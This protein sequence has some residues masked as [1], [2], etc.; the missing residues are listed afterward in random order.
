MASKSLN[1]IVLFCSG[2]MAAGGEQR[3]L[4]EEEKFFRAKGIETTV[5]TFSLDRSALYDYKPEKLEVIEAGPSFVSRII[6]LR[7][8]L[9]QINPDIVIASSNGG[10]VYL[11]LATMFTSIPYMVHIHGTLFWFLEDVIKYAFIHKKVFSGIRESVI[12]HKEFIPEQPNCS[13]SRRIASEFFAILDYLAVRK[14]RKIIVLTDQLKWEVEELYGREAVVARGCLPL[15]ALS[16]QPKEDVRQKLGLQNKRIIFSVGRLDPR[17][18]ID[19]LI[20]SFARILPKY[21]NL[22]LLIGGTG[23][24]EERLK[25]LAKELDIT[26][27]VKFLGFIPDAELF[28]YYAACDVFAFPSWTTSGITPYEALAV[29]K[30]VVWTTEADEPILGDE[31]VFLADPVVEDF[32]I[33]LEEAINADVKGKADLSDYTWDKYFETVYR[34]VIEAINK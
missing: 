5:L 25:K 32:A 1:K 17:K 2:L 30:K 34:A 20:K 9:Q 11:Y 19:V 18:R 4:W 26:E 15:E 14:A 31:H 13:F 16:Y 23:E 8:K 3:L 29:G 6:A 28:D 10:A 22:Y 27:R 12:G 21:G 7:R 33:G 24:E